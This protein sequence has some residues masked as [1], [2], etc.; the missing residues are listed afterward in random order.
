MEQFKRAELLLGRA[1]MERLAGSRVAVF[2]IGGVGGYVAEA[3]VRSGV[4]S[5]ELV[6]PDTVA[7]SNLNRQIIAT[8]ATLGR[9]KVDVMAERARDINPAV[10]VTTRKCFFLPETAGEFDFAAYDYVVDAVD[11]VA[12][13]LDLAERCLAAHTPL[14][15]C[16]GTGNKLDPAQLK[17]AD[18]SK[19]SM[20]P[21]ARVMRYELR[22]RG[23]RHLTVL[24]STEQPLSPLTEPEETPEP[25]RRAIP[26]STA[27][28][29][30]AA[31]LMIGGYVVQAL[32]GEELAAARGE[33]P[34][35][36]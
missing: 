2:G 21:L 32:T 36:T 7:L 34:A 35:S 29:P 27:F 33:G 14:I 8:H 25:G 11:T 31:G 15:S 12:A 30:A 23:I 13:K 9:Y 28:V 18:I 22:Q 17:I 26:G 16:M 6:D 3:L 1:A 24:Y 4:G 20:C 10:T 5:L 19:T